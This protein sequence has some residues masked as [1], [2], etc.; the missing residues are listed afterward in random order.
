MSCYCGSSNAFSQCC[1]PFILKKR[2][3]ETPEQLMRSRYSAYATNNP[4]YIF[5]TYAQQKQ[6]ENTLD[7]IAQWAQETQWLSLIIKDASTVS[8]EQFNSEY[9]PTVNFIAYYNHDKQFY[10][11]NECS[12]FIVEY[13]QWRYLD[14]D[15]TEHKVIQAPKRNDLCFCSSAKKFKKCCGKFS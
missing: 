9:L 1:Q 14:G 6:Q 2:S 3:P 7:D 8:I 10:Q 11:M 4:Q 12:R 15:V 5:E 13:G